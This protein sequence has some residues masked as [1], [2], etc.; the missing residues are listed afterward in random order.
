MKT[1]VR[2]DSNAVALDFRNFGLLP[3][4]H[5]EDWMRSFISTKSTV[6]PS[7]KKAIVELLNSCNLDCPMCRVGQYGVNIERALS[8]RNFESILDQ[9]PSL[10]SVR[11]N[12]LGESTLVPQFS[13]Y[14]KTLI[15][16]DI[17]V[18]LITNGTGQL[19]DYSLV[20]ET[21]GHIAISWDAADKPT[22]ERL[23]RPDNWENALSR[24]EAV[25]RRRHELKKGKVSLLYTLQKANILH[26]SRLFPIFE[27][28]R[29]DSII[30]N[31]AK[32]DSDEWLR[33]AF[34]AICEEF[35]RAQKEAE[36]SSIVLF[37]PDQV[38]GKPVPLAN[39]QP[40]CSKHCSRPWEEAVFRWNGDVQVCNMFNPFTYGNVFLNTFE[41]IWNNAFARLFRAKIN[42][43][44][45]HP[46]CRDCVYFDSS[47]S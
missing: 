30:V 25:L 39:T 14:A 32:L 34:G 46:Y 43:G 7:P 27:G 19:A 15:R 1:A 9:L 5:R 37:L 10:E 33:D 17:R 26:L 6:V 20:L 23:R 24:T 18:E 11:L 29:P 42:T 44:L 2:P 38:A 16:R 47:Y 22:F 13:D 12:G 21:G 36:T 35:T 28:P 41:E 31:V 8:I 3:E 45:R 4:P 40:T